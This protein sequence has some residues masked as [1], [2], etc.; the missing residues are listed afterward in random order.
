MSSS[1]SLSV[2]YGLFFDEGECPWSGAYDEDGFFVECD[3]EGWLCKLYEIEIPE[4]E[5]A[6]QVVK[7][8]T[9]HELPFIDVY[10]GT[11]SYTIRAMVYCPELDRYKKTGP[12][13]FLFDSGTVDLVELLSFEEEARKAWKPMLEKM[14]KT[15]DD[16][17]W[18]CI[19]NYG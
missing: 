7:T 16:L 2:G 8:Q 14:G 13:C 1:L 3:F 11:D 6:F 15:E 17:G 19:I 10:G 9:K 4:K 5:Y 12:T 18:Q